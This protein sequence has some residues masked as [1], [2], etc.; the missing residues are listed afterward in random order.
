MTYKEFCSAY[1]GQIMHIGDSVHIHADRVEPGI[2]NTL[3]F[4]RNDKYIGSA[5]TE[6]NEF[7]FLS[8]GKIVKIGG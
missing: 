5:K 2:D 8:G 3:S 1:K 6:N 4:F 7:W